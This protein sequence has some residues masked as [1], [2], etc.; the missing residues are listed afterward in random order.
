MSKGKKF[1][2]CDRFKLALINAVNTA[3]YDASEVKGVDCNHPSS[4]NYSDLTFT[5]MRLINLVYES[6]KRE[7]IKSKFFN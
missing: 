2:S 1:P 5:E 3:I 4:L 7:L 6:K